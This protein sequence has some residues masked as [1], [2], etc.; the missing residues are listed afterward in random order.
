MPLDA[1]LNSDTDKLA[2]IGLKRSQEEP[3]VPMD[4]STVVQYHLKGRTITRDLKQSIREIPSVPL[5]KRSTTSTSLGGAT[6][7]L[8][9][10][11]GTYSGRCTKST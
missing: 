9:Q 4:P 8:T 10:W 11:I 5:L 6:P 3:K 7:S 1:Y 2:T